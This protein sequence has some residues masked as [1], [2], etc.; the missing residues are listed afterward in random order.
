LTDTPVKERIRQ[1]EELKTARKKKK[2]Q[3]KGQ[4]KENVKRQITRSKQATI[5]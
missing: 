3:R 4:G 2:E 1:E 5:S